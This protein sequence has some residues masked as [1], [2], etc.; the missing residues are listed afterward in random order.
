MRQ[1]EYYL[2]FNFSISNCIPILF[3]RS[4]F[5]GTKLAGVLSTSWPLVPFFVIT[6]F[7]SFHTSSPHF[8]PIRIRIADLYKT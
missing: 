5:Y 8:Q 7:V 3:R 6:L 2:L 4:N 1:S